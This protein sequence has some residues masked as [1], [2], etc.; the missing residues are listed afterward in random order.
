MMHFQVTTTRVSIICALILS[1]GGCLSNPARPDASMYGDPPR[2][3]DQPAKDAVSALPYFN[4]HADTWHFV[5]IGI[6]FRAYQNG[7]PAFGNK[8]VWNG[9]VVEVVVSVKNHIGYSNQDTFNI[10]FD[11]DKVHGV[12]GDATRENLNKF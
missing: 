10:L 7:V 1:L 11:G 3:Y 4:S 9:Y 8:L 6:P 2:A 12:V 5:S